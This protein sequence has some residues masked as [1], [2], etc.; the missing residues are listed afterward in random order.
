[1][2]DPDAVIRRLERIELDELERQLLSGVF[3]G[4]PQ[5]E[6]LAILVIVRKQRAAT[7]VQSTEQTKVARRA[8]IAAWVAAAITAVGIVV[9]AVVNLLGN[10]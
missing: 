3:S 1:M 9:T 5:T 4:D 6:R 7:E 8:M 10:P 2:T